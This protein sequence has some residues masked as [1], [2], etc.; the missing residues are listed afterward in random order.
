MVNLEGSPE[1]LAW[2]SLQLREPT[3]YSFTESF[4][5][6]FRTHGLSRIYEKVG[7]RVPVKVNLK[8]GLAVLV[9][10]LRVSAVYLQ[11]SNKG[12]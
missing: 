10:D 7:N 8:V 1:T 5:L 4:F 6:D 3:L 11:G 2:L 12:G 9:I